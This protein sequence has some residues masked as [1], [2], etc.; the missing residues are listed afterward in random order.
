M[1]NKQTRRKRGGR[2]HRGISVRAIRRDPPNPKKL[3]QALIALALAQAEKDA[4][5][6]TR[7]DVE[8]RRSA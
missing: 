3:S 2:P 6:Q 1:S 8:K 4:E 7:G 5:A